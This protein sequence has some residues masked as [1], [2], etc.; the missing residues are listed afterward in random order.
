MRA[1][2]LPGPSCKICSSSTWRQSVVASSSL[3][4]QEKPRGCG[5]KIFTKPVTPISVKALR[6]SPVAAREFAEPPW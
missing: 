3:L 2:M 4:P 6:K 5:L 1:A